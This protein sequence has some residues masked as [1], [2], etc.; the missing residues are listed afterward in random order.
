MTLISRLLAFGLSA[1]LSF[2]AMGSGTIHQNDVARYLAGLAP[3]PESG[4]HPLTREPGWVT[5][6][7]QLGASW[8]HLERTQLE[9]VRTWSAQHLAP[10]NDTLLYMF[11]G[12][13][14]LYARNFF[15]DAR[16]YVLAGLE[17]GGRIINLN[18]F[19]PEERQVGLER[20]RESLKTIF[21]ASFF[22][23]ADM[24]KDL[25]GHAFSGVLPLLY[26]FLARSGMEIKDV[27]HVGL[28]E[29]GSTF[30]RPAP[31]RVRPNGLEILFNDPA[32][33]GERRLIYFSIDLSNAGLS[34]GAFLRFIER[35]GPADAFF[36]SASYLPHE[37]NF[38]SIREAVLAKSTRI[39][40]DDT[41][42]PF[43]GYDRSAWNLK[44]FGTYIRPIQ[45]FDYM[46]QP[47]LAQFFER[48]SPAPLN[49]R[50]GYG[51]GIST[52][53]ILLAT[54]R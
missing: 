7:E 18:R 26:L 1:T 35:L 37:E 28:A 16:T 38:R 32:R 23:T 53:G 4:A 13:D 45:M 3:S 46:Y 8:A 15:P 12:P 10:A 33:G 54:R 21:D 6:A 19:S 20:L 39:L 47:G 51:Y 5:H 25:Q 48:G 29:D 52:T 14:Y 31:A 11:S 36:K 22:V 49:F 17:P 43:A 50:L 27:R 34:D 42:V 2:S 41:G 9:P 24:L 44:P 30:V 40:Q